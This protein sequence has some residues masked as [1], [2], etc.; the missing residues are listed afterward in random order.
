MMHEIVVTTIQTLGTL[1]GVGLAAHFVVKQIKFGERLKLKLEIY[2]EILKVAQ[3]ATDAY[4]ALHHQVHMFMYSFISIWSN[5]QKYQGLNPNPPTDAVTMINLNAEA[6]MKASE[7]LG[8]I[9]N[10]T[11]IDPRVRVF[12]DAI[13]VAV[14]EMRN[15]W[16]EVEPYIF[17]STALFSLSPNPTRRHPAHKEDWKGFEAAM[18]KYSDAISLLDCYVADLKTEMQNELLGELFNSKSPTRVPIDPKYRAINLKDAEYWHDYFVNDTPWGAYGRQLDQG[19]VKRLLA[20]RDA[21]GD[22]A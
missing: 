6:G 19:N 5:K 20:M 21:K 12:H 13:N 3:S 15:A 22:G 4:G 18:S 10:W 14:H 7:V 8:L 2:K 17:R 9:E 1:A 11:V 16:N